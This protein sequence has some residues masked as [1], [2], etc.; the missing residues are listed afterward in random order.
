MRDSKLVNGHVYR[1]TNPRPRRKVHASAY[2]FSVHIVAAA[3]SRGA[4]V[5]GV[6]PGRFYGGR[7]RIIICD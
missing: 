4:R 7:S 6:D 2:V 5:A 3:K 1:R